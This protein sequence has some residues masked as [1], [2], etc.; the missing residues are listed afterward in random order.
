MAR[1]TTRTRDLPRPSPRALA[2]WMIGTAAV[3]GL[4]LAARRLA[5]RTGPVGAEH[6]APDLA[7]DQPHPGPDDRAP[8]VFRPDPTAPV[9]ESEREGLRPATGPA[10]RLAGG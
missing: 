8:E 2:L 5:G 4:A 9:P 6:L 1:R 10:P 7:L 3:A